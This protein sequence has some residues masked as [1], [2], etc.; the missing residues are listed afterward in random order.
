M[1]F[2]LAFVR[3][4]LEIASDERTLKVR[5][6]EIQPLRGLRGVPHAEIAKVADAA[7]GTGPRLPRDA[8]ALEEL[9]VGSF[10]DGLV[11]I[12]LLAG[13]GPD[14]AEAAWE[15]GSS[16]LDRVD[17]NETADAL[18]WMVLGPT[19][20]ITGQG[21]DALLPLL[22]RDQHAAVRRA[23][24]SA[25]LA[26]TPEPLRGPAAAALRA[27][28]QIPHVR[29]VEAPLIEPLGRLLDVAAR[30]PEPLVQKA[31]RRVLS[32]WSEADPA[33]ALDW[34]ARFKGGLPKLLG[35]ALRKKRR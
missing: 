3:T 16:W 4:A 1:S 23:A 15:L 20:L 18:G 35:E 11:A 14:A 17:D 33:S 7:W 10:E 19:A 32:A 30:D 25:G 22:A 27:R 8:A 13:I 28:L 2:S 24:V 29:F 5:R 9:F 31:V 26:M 6:R 12:A 21:V 34:A